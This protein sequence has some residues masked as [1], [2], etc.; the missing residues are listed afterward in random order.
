MEEAKL[1]YRLKTKTIKK[2]LLKK[3]VLK[4]NDKVEEAYGEASYDYKSKL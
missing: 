4:K 3:K 1:R 2:Y